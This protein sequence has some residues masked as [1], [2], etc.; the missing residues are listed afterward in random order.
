MNSLNESNQIA[1]F[2]LDTAHLGLL[3]HSCE[4][5]LV[6][7]AADSSCHGVLWK[8]REKQNKTKETRQCLFFF[9]FKL[10]EFQT[11]YVLGSGEL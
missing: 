9:L 11:S 3:G 1:S 10:P 4:N 5:P 7:F 8:E 6:L 2:A